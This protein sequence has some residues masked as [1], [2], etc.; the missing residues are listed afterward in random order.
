MSQNRKV[1]GK[2]GNGK[3]SKESNEFQIWREMKMK[4]V[5]RGKS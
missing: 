2:V 3:Q 5:K 1:N 4:V